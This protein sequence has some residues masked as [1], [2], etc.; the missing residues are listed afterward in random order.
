VI[1]PLSCSV[2]TVSLATR[3]YVDDLEMLGYT[4]DAARESC[5]KWDAFRCCILFDGAGMGS[6]T[7]HQIQGQSPTLRLF[8]HIQTAKMLLQC[9]EGI[10]LLESQWLSNATFSGR[11]IGWFY[12]TGIW[13]SST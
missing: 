5:S 12:S 1:H 4:M 6:R 7:R 13:C 11:F 8:E 2:V 3:L 9:D 10:E